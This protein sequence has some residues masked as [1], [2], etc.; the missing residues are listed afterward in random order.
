M[1]CPLISDLIVG[2]VECSEC[3]YEVES[4]W[5][6]EKEQDRET[7]REK[8]EMLLS[9]GVGDFWRVRYWIKVGFISVF[10]KVMVVL[11]T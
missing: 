3:L 1:L 10:K 2:E 7:K 9:Y 4:S 5:V 6:R 8:E 11:L